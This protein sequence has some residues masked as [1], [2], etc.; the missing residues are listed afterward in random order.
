MEDK[1]APEQQ[2]LA[3]FALAM[4]EPWAPQAPAGSSLGCSCAP[5]SWSRN[6]RNAPGAEPCPAP[7]AA[8]ESRQER[9][10]ERQLKPL[11]HPFAGSVRDNKPVFS[12]ICRSWA[13]MGVGGSL[14]FLGKSS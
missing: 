1:G 6:P 5:L 4:Q 3:G 8:M 7:A 9:R 10:V 14:A 2:V 11:L 13:V 12:V